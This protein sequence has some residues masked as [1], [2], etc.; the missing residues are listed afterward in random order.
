[1]TGKFRTFSLA[2]WAL[3]PVLSIPS[4]Y[5]DETASK[6]IQWHSDVRVATKMAKEQNKPL[7]IYVTSDDCFYCRKMER[8]TWP[9]E[10][11]VR[12]VDAHFVALKLTPEN[13]L[14][15]IRNLNVPAFPAT[16]LLNSQLKHQQSAV[17]LQS[18]QEVTRMLGTLLPTQTQSAVRPVEYRP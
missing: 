1:M 10:A 17:G 16:L 8:Q 13:H 7:L 9:D 12:A 11:V 3:L 15:V 6:E 18:A 4:S 2:L 14:Q 5:A